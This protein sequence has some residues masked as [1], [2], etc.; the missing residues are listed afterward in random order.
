MKLT[1]RIDFAGAEFSEEHGKRMVRN[2]V[3]LGPVSSHG[4]T[5]KQ[6][7]M[8]EA[9]SKNLYEGTR[10]F[11][12]HSRDGRD[13]MHLAGVFR[14]TRHEDGKV[15]GTAHLLNDDY[16]IK[17]WNIA[18]TMPEAAGCSHVADGKLETVGGKRV[19]TAISKVH[20]VD[21]VV[22]GATTANVFEQGDDEDVVR[23][24]RPDQRERQ[25]EFIPRCIK[26]V[27]DGNNTISDDQAGAV[28]FM[29]WQARFEDKQA[30]GDLYLPVPPTSESNHQEADGP[31]T[32][33]IKSGRRAGESENP[34]DSN[35]DPRSYEESIHRIASMAT[36]PHAMLVEHFGS[37]L[38]R[39]IAR[40]RERLAELRE[41]SE[42]APRIAESALAKVQPV[43]GG[44]DVAP[45]DT[46]ERRRRLA[47]MGSPFFSRFEN[48]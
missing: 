26:M 23:V 20:S 12:N 39:N 11:I 32:Q 16:G 25:F 30:D 42:Q 3:M 22:Q 41:A 35:F 18:K 17:F 10:I 43:A 5:Y 37:S 33:T 47:A 14:D 45:K 2:V 46:P 27:Q 19:V 1:E 21:L 7:A 9:V 15:K 13:L 34:M 48:D 4:Y 24:P 6:S 38:D 36:L 28:C 40:H 31:N 44:F 8:A 29:A